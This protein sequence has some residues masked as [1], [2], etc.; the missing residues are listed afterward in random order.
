MLRYTDKLPEYK[1]SNS[2]QAKSG[3]VRSKLVL[4]SAGAE[5]CLNCKCSTGSK[6]SV[7][8]ILHMTWEMAAIVVAYRWLRLWSVRSLVEVSK[9]S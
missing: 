1:S 5:R 9:Y 8:S 3:S 7:T 6:V 4:Y 2:Y